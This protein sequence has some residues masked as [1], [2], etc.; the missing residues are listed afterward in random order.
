MIR[1]GQ[2]WSGQVR[3][4]Q[5]RSDMSG[6]E[7]LGQAKTDQDGSHIGISQDVSGRE[8]GGLGQTRTCQK[9]QNIKN[10]QKKNPT[11]VK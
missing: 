8:Q 7:S 4:G 2:N 6:Q 3:T 10:T 5:D 11:Y 1:T 9:T